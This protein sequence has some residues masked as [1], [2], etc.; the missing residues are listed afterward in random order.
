MFHIEERE[1]YI[2]DQEDVSLTVL[3]RR[4]LN[5]CGFSLGQRDAYSLVDSPRKPGFLDQ[6][7]QTGNHGGICPRRR[8]AETV[9]DIHRPEPRDYRVEIILNLPV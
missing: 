5:G 4:G 6:L 1:P 8:R 9:F 7:L 3:C 2:A